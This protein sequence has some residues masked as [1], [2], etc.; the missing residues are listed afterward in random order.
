[1]KANT[2][3]FSG[4]SREDEAA[5][6]AM[7]NGLSQ[8]LASV[9]SLASEND[10]E[11]VVIDMD[12]VYGYMTWLKAQ[13]AGKKTAAVTTSDRSDANFLLARPL[14]ANHLLKLLNDVGSQTAAAE[15][16]V[17]IAAAADKPVQLPNAE[18]LASS[19]AVFPAP[20]NT[21]VTAADAIARVTG[22]HVAMPP[23]Q[24]G[25]KKLFHFL[26]PGALKNPC[27]LT[28]ADAPDLVIDPAGQAYFA[29]AALKPLLAY[30]S[31][32]LTEQDFQPLSDAQLAQ[33]KAAS[34]G[35]QPLSRLIWLANLA[36]YG[37]ELS[38]GAQRNGEFHLSKWPATEREFPKHFRIAT[39]MVK[40]PIKL[41]DVA[42]QSGASLSDV[43][44]FVN[45]NIATGHIKL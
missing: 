21:T 7:F 11:L 26:K 1:M 25:P 32:E 31:V 29:G 16:T 33:Y 28:L 35:A 14:K 44:D 12:T 30:A 8:G 24:N 22:Q 41:G 6:I 37:G 5:A 18:P 43:I 13:S 15:P 3:C 38:P 36:G 17:A 34:T 27:R 9:W 4:F 10:A 23:L 2:I 40:A 20:S 19:K 42:A 45:A 39:I